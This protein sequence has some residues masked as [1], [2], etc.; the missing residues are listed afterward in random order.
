MSVTRR[1]FILIPFTSLLARRLA[2]AQGGVLADESVRAILRRRIDD[3]NRAT[4]MAVGIVEEGRRRV[5]VVVL[6]NALP[7][8]VKAPPGGGVGAADLARHL[9]RPA[10]PV[11]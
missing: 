6:S 5:V 11:G 10:F 7:V 9:I 1:T 4:G 2:E 3:E 8:K